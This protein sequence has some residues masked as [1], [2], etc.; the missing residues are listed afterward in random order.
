MEFIK[1]FFYKSKINNLKEDV[2]QIVDEMATYLE[3]EIRQVPAPLKSKLDSLSEK[4]NELGKY[5]LMAVL[6]IPLSQE[7]SELSKKQKG[8]VKL[9]PFFVQP[10]ENAGRDGEKAL[11]KVLFLP[12]YKNHSSLAPF[13]MIFVKQAI[14]TN[15]KYLHSIFDFHSDSIPLRSKVVE[16]F[17]QILPE[18]GLEPL[19]LLLER[20]KKEEALDF[21][22]ALKKHVLPQSLKKYEGKILSFLEK[23]ST[24]DLGIYLLGYIRKIELLEKHIDSS[25][26]SLALPIS[27]SFH[28]S[29]DKLKNFYHQFFTR[30]P[31]LLQP[32]FEIAV[33]RSLF[34]PS[35][36]KLELLAI[37]H[38]K[39]NLKSHFG[40]DS[41][42]HY[43]PEWKSF[44]I[45]VVQKLPEL[46]PPTGMAFLKVMASL[47]DP[48]LVPRLVQIYPTVPD[49]HQGI[50]LAVSKL[51]KG[52]RLIDI[53]QHFK[54]RTRSK[55]VS[56]QIDR[57]IEKKRKEEFQ[58]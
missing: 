27:F 35:E 17:G 6:E 39:E 34:T 13:I 1:N 57:I 16:I 3:G 50:V 48:S 21:F 58:N 36:E 44:L 45:E 23:D 22:L 54:Q 43:R 19:F 49:L 30:Y 4:L 5:S 42:L 46:P 32:F 38:G 7:W 2:M 24:C 10:L 37:V 33:Q 52:D 28:T 26:P 8:V 14:Y 31:Q 12:Q 40:L 15:Q 9:L 11:K 29:G 47:Q 25:P 20:G 51:A 53:L 55:L 18:K 56:E 41:L